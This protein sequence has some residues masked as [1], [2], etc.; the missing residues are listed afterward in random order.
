MTATSDLLDFAAAEHSL[1]AQVRADTL[2]LLADALAVGAAGSTAPGME[3]VLAVARDW[4]QGGEARLLGR[5]E[6]MPVHGAAYVNGFAVHC[7]EWDAVH[8]PAVVHSVSSITAALLAAIDRKG[9]CD[10]DEALTALAVGIDIASGIGLAAE[11]DLTFFRPATAGIFGAA[12]A[13]ARIEGL[14]REQF[15]DVLGLAH[16]HA[17]GTMQA[18]REGSIALP[19]QFANA[20]RSAI[21]AVDLAKNGL[22][23]PHDPLEGEF[24]HFRLFDTGSLSTYTKD[25]GD[26]WRVP[27]VST[28]PYPSGRASH[29]VLGTLDLLKRE[30]LDAGGIVSIEAF[31]PSLINT[32]V[33]RPMKADMTPAYARL[34][35]PFL[36]ALMLTDG[37]IDPRRFAPAAFGD[38]ALQALADRLVIT[39]DGNPDPNALYPQ[40]IVAT[41][42]SGAVHDISVPATL[43]SPKAPMSAEQAVAKRDLA[44]SLSQADPDPRLF[45]DPL[46]YFT[47]PR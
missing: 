15:D 34:C 29:A 46:A 37:L 43:G 40:R 8:E 19:L 21:H 5:S 1:P 38:P 9:W 10:P 23:G 6:R 16:A 3:G 28:K 25:I 42:A 47:D 33:G 39:I 20:V 12:L 35:L 30:G 14:R 13:V 11:T 32:L 31:V 41:M 24:G 26:V 27:E 22:A 4:G 45:D 2:R 17:A 36:S 7:L 18:H 44:R